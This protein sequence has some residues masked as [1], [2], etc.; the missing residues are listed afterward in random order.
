MDADVPLAT[1]VVRSLIF[2][3]SF[4]ARS[5][6]A[7][8]E[9]AFLSMDKWAV[10]GL[11]STGDP[12]ARVLSRLEKDTRSTI[13]AILIGTNVCT[14]LASVLGASIASLLGASEMVMLAIVPLALTALLFLLTELVPKTYSAGMPTEIA[15]A[16]APALS[17]LVS[18][19]RPISFVLSAVPNMFAGMLSE[20]KA[21]PPPSS[22][23]PVRV[24]LDL[25]AVEGQ[26]DKEDGDVITG[27]LDSSDTRIK[28]V[29]IPISQVTTLSSETPVCDALATFS[30]H[31][32]SRVPV[33]SPE[34]GEVLGIVYMKDVVR[35]A[36]KAPA[37]VTPI[38]TLMRAPFRA[39][40]AENLLD[41]LARMRKNR[42][43]FAVVSEDRRTLGIVTMEDILTEIV[44]DIPEDRP[45]KMAERRGPTVLVARPDDGMTESDGYDFAG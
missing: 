31:R 13:S 14:V 15:L 37:C 4:L 41:V 19:L 11:A 23:E 7:G 45:A 17:V 12:R 40:P 33:T 38:K 22:D 5:F 3:V 2:I 10:E 9:T 26:V 39:S 30:S 28:D 18:V 1:V 36:M 20:R 43:H 21:A 42:V 25:A 16:I 29:M 34:T 6:F 24:A 44:G 8:S 27:V 32:F 35:E